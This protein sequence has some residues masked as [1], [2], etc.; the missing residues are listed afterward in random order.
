MGRQ[1]DFAVAVLCIFMCMS[2]TFNAYSG[3][4]M[5]AGVRCASFD[6]DADRIVY[7]YLDTGVSSL[8]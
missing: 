7:Y 1:R 5:T 3:L 8:L 6:G 4:A 2:F